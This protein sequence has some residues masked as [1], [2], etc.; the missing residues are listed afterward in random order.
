MICTSPELHVIGDVM[1]E[2]GTHVEYETGIAESGVGIVI[3][4]DEET[5]T[6]TVKDDD[7]GSIWRGSIDHAT[8]IGESFPP[9]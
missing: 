6:V 9:S 2:I 4:F 1:M 7:D 3:E 8:R 5:E